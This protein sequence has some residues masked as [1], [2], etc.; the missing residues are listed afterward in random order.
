FVAIMAAANT[1]SMNFRDRLNEFATLKSLGFSR[2]FAMMLIGSESLLLCAAG[3]V[4]G[5]MIPFVAFTWTPLKD[6][7]VPLIQHLEIHPIVCV[8]AT[9]IAVLIG[10][11]AGL[12]PA[13]LAFR[14]HVVNALRSLE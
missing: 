13:W 3:G 14:M 4:A 9:A 5:A 6:F 11:T 7:T 8:K 1:M 12:W 2:R 10:L